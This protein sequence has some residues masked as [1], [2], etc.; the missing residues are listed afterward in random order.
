MS[1]RQK[2]LISSSHSSHTTYN[3]IFTFSVVQLLL[4]TTTGNRSYRQGVFY[5]LFTTIDTS[6]IWNVTKKL[7]MLECSI[8]PGRMVLFMI[9]IKIPIALN[10]KLHSLFFIGHLPSPPLPYYGNCN[11]SIF[12]YYLVFPPNHSTCLTQA[13]IFC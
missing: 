12:I 3:L 7:Q 4:I 6:L 9:K 8:S 11:C 13:T 5:T 2:V 1:C 10:G